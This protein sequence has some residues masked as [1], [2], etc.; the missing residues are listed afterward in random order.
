M[1]MTVLFCY[2][3]LISWDSSKWNFYEYTTNFPLK[4]VVKIRAPNISKKQEKYR[5][6][7]THPR[8]APC[9]VRFY[10]YKVQNVSTVYWLKWEKYLRTPAFTMAMTPKNDPPQRSPWQ[11]S[12]QPKERPSS[13]R[14]P[15]LDENENQKR[16]K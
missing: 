10:F 13:L 14:H 7:K 16:I 4:Q 12:L 3:R 2:L 8:S 5:Y 9:L 6:F 11:Q 1:T 15:M